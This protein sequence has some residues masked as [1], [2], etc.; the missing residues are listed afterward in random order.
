M[1]KLTKSQF[2]F[3]K[4]DTIGAESAELDH[5]YLEDCYYD[6]GDLD[7]IRDCSNSSCII[8]G[9]TGSGKTALILKLQ[10]NEEH[11]ISIEPENLWYVAN[12]I[13]N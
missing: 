12:N 10:E 11:I 3:R 7:V 4:N 9:R 5:S 2:S 6:R 8:V 13:K 1:A